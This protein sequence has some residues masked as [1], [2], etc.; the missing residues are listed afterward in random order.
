MTQP[1]DSVPGIGTEQEF[2]LD[3]GSAM[4][5][6]FTDWSATDASVNSLSELTASLGIEQTEENATALGKYAAELWH[7]GFGRGAL[8]GGTVYQ[9]A[10]HGMVA[11]WEADK[12]AKAEKAKAP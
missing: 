2:L 3:A 11:E 4:K 6:A 5:A 1:E 10:I 8:W 7:V 9:K 12:K